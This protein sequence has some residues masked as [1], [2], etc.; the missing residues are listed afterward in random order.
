MIISVASVELSATSV[1]SAAISA[2][3][4]RATVAEAAAIADLVNQAY[5]AEAFFVDGNRTTAAEIREL[6]GEGE[7]LVIDGPRGLA[8]AIF[9]DAYGSNEGSTDVGD[10][11]RGAVKQSKISMVS[12]DPDMQRLGIGRRLVAIAEALSSALGSDVV[13]L[14]VVSAREDLLRWYRGLGYREVGVAP[15]LHRPTKQPC[16]FVLFEKSLPVRDN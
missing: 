2:S 3:A 8:G 13:K 4:R 10:A 7:F 16:H 6:I 5:R 11:G 15:Y 14:E 9:I 12:V 1:R